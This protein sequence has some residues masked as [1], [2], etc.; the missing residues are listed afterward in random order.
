MR[1]QTV[2]DPTPEDLATDE[3]CI[4]DFGVDVVLLGRA[5][6]AGDEGLAYLEAARRPD[7]RLWLVDPGAV[8]DGTCRPVVPVQVV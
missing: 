8:T 2:L 7:R 1:G 3:A 4:D 5:T 6:V